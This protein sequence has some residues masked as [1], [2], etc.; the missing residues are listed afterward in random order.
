MAALVAA[1]ALPACQRASR[2]L[3]IAQQV[4][5]A[6]PSVEADRTDSGA[7]PLPLPSIP[8]WPEFADDQVEPIDA[9]TLSSCT[10][11]VLA[12]ADDRLLT[13]HGLPPSA[14]LRC[15]VDPLSVTPYDAVNVVCKPVDC[16]GPGLCFV[17]TY[18]VVDLNGDGI[19]DVFVEDSR[20]GD[21]SGN[22]PWAIFLSEDGCFRFAGTVFDIGPDPRTTGHNGALDLTIYS[23]SSSPSG[24]WAPNGTWALWVYDGRGYTLSSSVDCHYD[25]AGHRSDPR[26][27]L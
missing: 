21:P 8:D 20:L 5:S 1:L 9:G 13:E 12:E 6:P 19:T 15:T 14:G 26:C 18:R 16:A 11:K 7:P 22:R 10:A 4:S 2:N 24:P 3:T 27:P 23:A 17:T 25:R